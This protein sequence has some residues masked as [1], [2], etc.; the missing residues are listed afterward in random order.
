MADRRRTRSAKQDVL[1][2]EG[3]LNP[4]PDAVTDP[5][6]TER[7]FFDPSDLVQVKY[8]MLRRVDQDGAS[9]TSA[10]R[11]FGLSRPTFYESRRAYEGGGLLGLVPAKRGPRGPRKLTDEVMDFVEATIDDRGPT[12]ARELAHAIQEHFGLEVHPRSIER[13][14]A[15]RKRGV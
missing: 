10:S 12:G 4:H 6:F 2:E 9:V 7:G 5:L 11:A 1:K 8:E 15:R 14:L 3:V 13:A